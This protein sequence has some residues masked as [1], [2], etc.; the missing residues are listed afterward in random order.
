MQIL[1]L[2]LECFFVR[3]FWHDFNHLIFY[4]I[5]LEHPDYPLFLNIQTGGEA[6]VDSPEGCA[7]AIDSDKS[8]KIIDE[9][10]HKM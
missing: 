5:K 4:R 7:G 9:T 2:E 3:L 10:N 8:A 6:L 1:D